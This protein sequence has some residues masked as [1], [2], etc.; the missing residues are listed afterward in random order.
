MRA[1]RAAKPGKREDEI[2]AEF[3]MHCWKEYNQKLP[4]Y[5]PIVCSGR[6]CSVLHYGAN[7]EIIPDHSLLLTDMGMYLQHYASDITTTYPANG[8]F[9][10]KQR[11][12]SRVTDRDIYNI[13]LKANRT[14]QHAAGPGVMW[15][16]MHLLAEKVIL[17]G[18]QELGVIK[19]AANIEEL[20]A[21]RV[22]F[23]FMPHGLGHLIGLDVHDVGGYLPANPPRSKEPGLRSLRHAR[24]LKPGMVTTN[25]PGCY[26]IEFLLDG[27]GHDIDLSAIDVPK[28][29]EYLDVGGVRIEDAIHITD[30]GNEI[31]TPSFLPRSVDE[32]EAFMAQ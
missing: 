15:T 8:K 7:T 22:G 32:V 23:I 6:R 10:P 3:F 19:A 27:K 24:E 20:V 1:M 30:V 21:K 5:P 17:S 18:L 31:L 2:A 9:T 28:A 16:D 29:K 14:V 11:Y 4:A 26:F 25:E 12:G 13:V